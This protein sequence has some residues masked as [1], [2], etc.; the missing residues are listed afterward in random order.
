MNQLLG[1]NRTGTN[2]YR[3]TYT[4]DATQNR[5]LN[6]N[7]GTRTT[8]A[9]DAANQLKFSQAVAGR[10]TYTFDNS[11]NQQVSRDPSNN[12]TTTTWNFENQPTLY[13]LASGARV[14]STYNA[15]NRQAQRTDATATTNFTW[16]PLT[17]NVIEEVTPGGIIVV[18]YTNKPNQFGRLVSENRGGTTSYY[19]ADAIGSTRL[20]TNS[21]ESEVNSYLYSA[22]GETVASVQPTSTPY[23]FCGQIGYHTDS[24]VGNAY[25]R[26]RTYQ[27]PIARWSSVDPLYFS[28]VQQ[29]F[30]QQYAFAYCSNCPITDADPSGLQPP[31]DANFPL[32]TPDQYFSTPTLQLPPTVSI[33][34]PAGPTL[35]QAAWVPPPPT[36][37]IPIPFLGGGG[38]SLN[39]NDPLAFDPQAAWNSFV[40]AL[41]ARLNSDASLPPPSPVSAIT[42]SILTALNSQFQPR[43]DIDIQPLPAVIQSVVAGTAFDLLAPHLPANDLA[44]PPAQIF[45]NEYL[46]IRQGV[47]I[48]TGAGHRP[49]TTGF[50]TV[51]TTRRRILFI[52]ADA[53]VGVV[54]ER[55]PPNLQ[56]GGQPSTTVRFEFGI[57]Y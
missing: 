55:D 29:P 35:P 20:T 33:T 16:N 31:P 32:P 50:R 28:T 10:T 54:V 41:H 4:Y 9:Y 57:T 25:V 23:Q 43:V 49:T 52:P 5:T 11:G 13:K 42:G 21:V 1:E 40:G 37:T 15:G 24:V 14:S 56:L 34:F 48:H 27:P 51:I 30:L 53:S 6:N 45:S 17:D 38:A 22:W 26:A 19:H 39:I 2:P 36:T 46:A 8:F 7:A 12:R 44:V 3:Q 18:T 47:V